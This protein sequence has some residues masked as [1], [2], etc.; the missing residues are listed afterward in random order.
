MHDDARIPVLFLCTG[1][2][3]RSVLAEVLL[4]SLAGDRFVAHSAGS[5]PA[6]KVN[7]A[8]VAQLEREGHSTANL[9]SKSWDEFAE[10]GAPSFR[11]VFTVCDNAA[12][13]SCPV[14]IGTPMTVH[15]G[16]PD[17]AAVT[18]PPD[19]VEAAFSRAYGQ[20]RRRIEGLIA[21]PLDELSDDEIRA[22]L[23]ALGADPNA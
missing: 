9:Q 21:L 7:P 23:E 13:E 18:E 16:V 10:T 11:L 14:W 1:N 19:A 22:R 6:G 20:M 2:S 8:A 12:G 3:A 15:W 4:N 5:H 17:P